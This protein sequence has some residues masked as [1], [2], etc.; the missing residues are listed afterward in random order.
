M[1]KRHARRVSATLA[2][3]SA[4]D[5]P[6]RRCPHPTETGPQP[7]STQIARDNRAPRRLHPRKGQSPAIAELRPM[8][9][10]RDDSEMKSKDMWPQIVQS[11]VRL[12]SRCR[13]MPQKKPPRLSLGRSPAAPPTRGS[14]WHVTS[15][16]VDAGR[17]A[18]SCRRS[19]QCR[20]TQRNDRHSGRTPPRKVS[21]KNLG[22]D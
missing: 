13:F 12:A 4:L 11:R 7:V 22:R 18:S 8:K 5:R 19:P 15:A 6:S 20:S 21:W 17:L 3:R 16:P 9:G 1:R 2:A 10:K 14:N